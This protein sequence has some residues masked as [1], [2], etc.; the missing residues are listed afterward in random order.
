MT[1]ACCFKCH[2]TARTDIDHCCVQFENL[3]YCEE[4]HFWLLFEKEN[5]FIIDIAANFVTSR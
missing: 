3:I 4:V 2:Y 1:I 5:I